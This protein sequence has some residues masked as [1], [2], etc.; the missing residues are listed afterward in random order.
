LLPG[1]LIADIGVHRGPRRGRAHPRPVGPVAAAS[2]LSR[3]VRWP[4]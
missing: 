4:S 3:P 1:P 2:L